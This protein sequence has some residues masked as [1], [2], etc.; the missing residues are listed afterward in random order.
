[1]T[2]HSLIDDLKII[3]SQAK[4]ITAKRV[5]TL[6]VISNFVIGQRIVQDDQ[7]GRERANY[8]KNTVKKLSEALTAEFGRG[9]SHRNLDLM[10]KFYLTYAGKLSISQSA[11]AKLELATVSA[12]LSQDL[13]V[14]LPLSWSHYIFLMTIHEEEVR[15]FYEIESSKENWSLKEVKRQFDSALYERL[16]LSQD[17]EGI[18]ALALEG[19]LVNDVNDVIKDPYVLEFLG[20]NEETKYSENE[21]ETAIINKIELFLLELGKGFLFESRQKRFTFDEQHFYVDLVFYNRL[22]KCYVIIDLKIGELKHQDLGQMQMYVNYFDRFVKLDDE[23][24]TIGI[25]LCHSKS[26]DLVELTLPA[27]SNIHASK[28]QLYLPSKVELQKELLKAEQDWE[29]RCK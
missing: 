4:L 22:L 10:K 9:Y 6:Q 19:Q 18:K 5:N 20:L 28:Y 8:G 2:K 26:D 13:A 15:N 21:M 25:L 27:D 16:V 14:K 11:S 24:K 29:N 12:L 17:K 23:N 1:M 7:S 3:I